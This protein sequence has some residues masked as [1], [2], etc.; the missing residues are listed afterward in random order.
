MAVRAVQE[1]REQDEGKRGSGRQIV[2]ILGKDYSLAEAEALGRTLAASFFLVSALSMI[3]M[4]LIG[5][6]IDFTL[7]VGLGATQLMQAFAMSA[8]DGAAMLEWYA[9]GLAA[10]ALFGVLGWR[11]RRIERWP[12]EL[13]I[14]LYGSDSVFFGE[15]G[16]YF[17]LGFHIAGLMVIVSG[18]S[19]VVLILNARK[20]SA[21]KGQQ[22]TVRLLGGHGVPLAEAEVW[23]RRCASVFFF[24]S[25]LSLGNMIAV[26]T[27]SELA[28]SM[29]LLWMGL[30]V[31]QLAR[32]L[33]ADA[34][35][36]ALTPYVAGSA[37][38]V[39]LAFIGWRAHRIER[40]P[41]V[42][43]MGL[44][45]ADGLVFVAFRDLDSLM[46]HV[47]GFALLWYG[48]AAVAPVHDGR[49]RASSSPAP[50]EEGVLVGELPGFLRGKEQERVQIRR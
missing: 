18:G 47:T 1:T 20:A 7:P 39:L 16:D 12:Y 31:T 25:V 42:L 32:A 21:E 26:A 27:G 14:P 22:V 43:G 41:F 11:A 13:G 38:A 35:L 44:Y 6:G 30:G 23:C 3:N 4:I 40:W 15:S 29:G 49:R 9:A 45:A 5:A 10:A 50:S 17:A 46:V 2:N 28:A 19:I 33:T 37:A 48:A 8:H 34:G 36:I 24:I